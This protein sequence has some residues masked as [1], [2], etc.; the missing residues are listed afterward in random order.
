MHTN[1]NIYTYILYIQ[2]FKITNHLSKF[3]KIRLYI[4]YSEMN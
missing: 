3:L 1:I 2:N 4:R